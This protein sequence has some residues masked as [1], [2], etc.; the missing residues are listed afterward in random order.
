MHLNNI[1]V[2]LASSRSTDIEDPLD[3]MRLTKFSLSLFQHGG[4]RQD[5]HGKTKKTKR[6]F[7]IMFIA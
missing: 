7:L 1:A 2:C 4:F 3:G 5:K 6:N